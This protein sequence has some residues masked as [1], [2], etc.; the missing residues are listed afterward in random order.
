MSASVNNSGG[1]TPYRSKEELYFSWWLDELQSAGFIK[2][3]SYELET[4][5]LAKAKSYTWLK[6]LKTKT[7]T[8]AGELLKAHRYTP[9]FRIEWDINRPRLPF[10]KS[11]ES[12]NK[13][14]KTDI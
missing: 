2:S 12:G 6:H 7:N 1:N 3:W 10:V 4:F 8:V 9:D 11:L 13:I 14:L 5:T